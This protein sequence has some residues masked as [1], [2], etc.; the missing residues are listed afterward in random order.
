[1]KKGLIFFILVV[2]LVSIV[3]AETELEFISPDKEEFAGYFLTISFNDAI[4]KE[5]LKNSK[6]N[7][8]FFSHTGEAEV[9]LDNPETPN[10]DYYGV[11]TINNLDKQVIVYPVGKVQGEVVDSK[12]NLIPYSK[13]SFACNSPITVEF[14]E[15]TN[16]VG[17][18]TVK[19]V[20]LGECMMFSSDGQSVG[21]QTF[22]IEKGKT[23]NAILVLNQ[24]LQKK[25]NFGL[26]YF[27]IIVF[28]IGIVIFF[29]LK[30]KFG[31]KKDKSH[32]KKDETVDKKE[33]KSEVIE[34]K[35]SKK[36]KALIETFSA[37]EK[38]VVHFLLENDNKSSQ[39]KIRHAT[40]IPR[41]SLT[42]VLK[43]LEGKKI[44]MIE[45]QG[46]H[47]DVA[48]SSFFLD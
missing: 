17:I 42:R 25:S 48:L 41:T 24:G 29:T 30:K 13:L 1:M 34:D 19:N 22:L 11:F 16:E 40:K 23:T 9:F 36:T 5:L 15:R 32:L 12:S 39:A 20:P 26:F 44:L 38:K 45:K 31:N 3:Y 28:L 43:S 27:L 18:F 2:L 46:K 4:H 35:L 21:K 8:E 6:L 33:T 47:V 7:F 14:P 10:N 37:K